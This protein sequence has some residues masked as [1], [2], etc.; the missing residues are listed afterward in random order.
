MGMLKEA[1]ELEKVYHQRKGFT[2]ARSRYLEDKFLNQR[3]KKRYEASL[4]TNSIVVEIG[5]KSKNI[6]NTSVLQQAHKT[7]KKFR[8]L[9]NQGLKVK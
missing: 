8:S 3:M 5:T 4:S 2:V 6:E 1:Y 9:K 7:T